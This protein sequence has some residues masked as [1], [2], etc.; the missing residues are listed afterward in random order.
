MA[1]QDRLKR[2]ASKV[3]GPGEHIQAVIATQNFH[4][5]TQLLGLFWVYLFN[6]RYRQVVATDQRIVVLKTKLTSY[7]HPVAVLAEFPRGMP[8]GPFGG[9]PSSIVV[10]GEK[11]YIIAGTKKFVG[12]ADETR[13]G[14]TSGAPGLSSP[15]ANA[16]LETPSANRFSPPP[17]SMNEVRFT[18]ARFVR[19]IA[20]TGGVL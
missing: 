9:P 20:V 6:G 8:L 4:P 16:S 15:N 5:V 10:N 1:L 3:L 17:L 2:S 11:L 18:S 19:T 14:A 12:V 7:R 13:P